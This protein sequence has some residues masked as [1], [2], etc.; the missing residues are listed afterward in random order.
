MK[1]INIIVPHYNGSHHIACLL[2]SIPN[3]PW[4]TVT[5]IDDH[6]S[7]RHFEVLQDIAER[8]DNVKLLQVPDGQKGPGIARNIGINESDANWLLFADADDYFIDGAFEVVNQLRKKDNDIIFFPP[9]SIIKETL[10]KSTRHKHYLRLFDQYAKSLNK[11]IF[12]K[13][14]APWSKLISRELLNDHDIRFDDGIGGE[15]NLFS[16]KAVFYSKSIDV[17]KSTIYC[18]VENQ[19]SMTANLS[20]QVLIN[21]YSAMSRYN[22]FLQQHGEPQYQ[23]WMLGWVFRGRQISIKNSISWLS[24]AINK[25]Y[26]I[27]PIRFFLK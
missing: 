19:G 25:G 1:N 16:L 2:N 15:D 12:Y 4:L 27:N 3:L 22:D 11:K 7:S 5:I 6:S 17:C 23:A 10:K 21:H 8:F 24:L 18:I 14:Y 9:T 20:D 13:F 26:P